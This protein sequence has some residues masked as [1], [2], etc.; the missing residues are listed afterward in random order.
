MKIKGF[1]VSSKGGCVGIRPE[2]SFLTR[3]VS[4]EQYEDSF[5]VVNY[6]PGL[7][8]RKAAPK[9]KIGTVDDIQFGKFDVCC[10][11]NQVWL[12]SH[13]LK[14]T[15]FERR[16]FSEYSNSNK[17]P[18]VEVWSIRGNDDKVNWFGDKEAAEGFAK[19][20]GVGKVKHC[21]IRNPKLVK[22]AI[23]LPFVPL[24][25]DEYDIAMAWQKWINDN[26]DMGLP[27]ILL[28]TLMKAVKLVNKG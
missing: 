12:I 21:K 4:K 18:F 10:A 24:F 8:L 2:Y 23:K 20:Y 11:D 5:P 9:G 26:H 16:L 28:E 27:C 15:Q 3:I 1:I 6:P 25:L 7:Y 19:F 22:T 17:D 14:P 13:Y